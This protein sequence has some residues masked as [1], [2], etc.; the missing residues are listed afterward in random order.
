MAYKYKQ[1]KQ[2][3]IGERWEFRAVLLA[4]MGFSARAISNEIKVRDRQDIDPKAVYKF[5]YGLGIRL[6]DYRQGRN[7]EAQNIVGQIDT[8]MRK[9]HD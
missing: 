4:R 6:N 1:V 9:A 7:E 2:F 5:V 8:T 3:E